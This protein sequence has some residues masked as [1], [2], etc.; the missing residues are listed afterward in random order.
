MNEV[1][2][3]NNQELPV[4]EYD[5]QRVVTFK[6]IDMIHKR[7]DGTARRNFN[8]NK[9]YFIEGEDFYKVCA[10]EIRTH[11]I[12]D[13]SSKAREDIALITESGYLM[14]VKSF[15]DDL[16]WDVQR[17]IVNKY[18]RAK[19]IPEQKQLTP[20]EMI[21]S[22][23]NN[24]VETERRLNLA[25]SKLNDM[26]T[27]I[28]NTSSKLN[29]ALDVFTET[30]AVPDWSSCMNRRISAVIKQN[31]FNHQT[32]RGNLYK[33]LENLARCNL[34]VRKANKQKRMKKSGAKSKDIQAVSK[35]DVISD[36]AKLRAIFD[37]IVRRFEARYIQGDNVQMGLP[38]E[39]IC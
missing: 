8:A 20:I 33:E 1:I 30:F 21:A 39:T 29:Q 10:D 38:E 23:A 27:S 2:L 5:G 18:F 31:G 25:E 34:N 14:L 16:A 36:D 3:I 15:T 4:K 26:Q 28:D 11:K 17:D 12:I 7:P 32:E 9:K 24:A 35:L 19:Y 6:D 22:I 37:G 13:I